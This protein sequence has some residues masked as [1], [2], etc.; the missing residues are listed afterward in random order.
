LKNLVV[1]QA[2][3][4]SLAANSAIPMTPIENIPQWGAA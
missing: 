3:D 4:A 2:I 1:N